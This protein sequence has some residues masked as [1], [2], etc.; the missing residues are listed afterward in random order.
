MHGPVDHLHA[1]LAALGATYAVNTVEVRPGFPMLLATL[2]RP[3]GGTTLLAGLPGNPQ[4]AIVALVSLVVPALAGLAGRLAAGAA[5]DPARRAGA[6]PRRLHASRA[7]PPGARRRRLAGRARR[8]VDAAR[9]R[10]GGRVRGDRAGTVRRAGRS[11]PLVP[12]P[13]F[14]RDGEFRG[15]AV[16]NVTAAMTHGPWR[17]S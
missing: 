16:T 6:G 17:A 13:L 15:A 14:R 9:T 11:G 5:D 8:V 7:R 1:A 2:P 12:L 10:P 4:S 3:D